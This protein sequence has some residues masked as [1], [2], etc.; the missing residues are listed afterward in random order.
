MPRDP[1][2]WKDCHCR[3]V[4]KLMAHQLTISRSDIINHIL[5]IQKSNLEFKIGVAFIYCNYNEQE[6][7]EEQTMS[8][9][10]SSIL[11]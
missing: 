10:L 2:C 1:W 9:L 4:P 3:G 7:Q 11:H 6:E 8:H 5:D